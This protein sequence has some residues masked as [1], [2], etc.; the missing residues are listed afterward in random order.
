MLKRRECQTLQIMISDSYTVG[1]AYLSG[2]FSLSFDGQ[3]TGQLPYD[4]SSE[5]VKASLEALCTVNSVSVSR[6]LICAH[7]IETKCEVEGFTWLVT[8][9]EPG[10]Q[11]KRHLS[12]LNSHISHK[13][14]IDDT[15]VLVC[16]DALLTSCSDDPSGIKASL[17]TQQEVQEIVML[18]Q[19]Q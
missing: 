1:D 10:D 16:T 11:H 9:K 17:G 14:S 6:T 8:F 7:T 4:A 15:Y 2:T 3:K 18:V 13:L 12:S 5:D 19:P